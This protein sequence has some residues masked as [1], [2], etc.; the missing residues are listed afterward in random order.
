MRQ[1]GDAL[2]VCP[3]A[4]DHFVR[5]YTDAIRD[6]LGYYFQINE[7]T[8][9][10]KLIGVTA[11]SSGAGVSTLA[12]GLAASCSEPGYGKVLLVDMNGDQATSHSFFEGQPVWTLPDALQSSAH[13]NGGAQDSHLYLARAESEQ[14]HHKPLK[15]KEFYDLL[16]QLALSDFDFIIFDMPPIG[17][18]SPT[19]AMAGFL[20]KTLLIVEAG[21]T[22]Q[23]D[24]KRGYTA[25]AANRADVS[26]VLNKAPNTPSWLPDESFY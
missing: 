9:K 3:W 17:P 21:K 15:T 14:A 26:L 23:E 6:R 19:T 1:N 8:H 12:A 25:L 24:C 22:T 7:M 13:L 20:D 18:T 5:P 10:P 11:F 2:T 16:P 4:E